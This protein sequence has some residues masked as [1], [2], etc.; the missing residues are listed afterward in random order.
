ML[1]LIPAVV[2]VIVLVISKIEI[3]ALKVIPLRARLQFVESSFYVNVR[4]GVLL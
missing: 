3:K 4:G 2:S 1:T